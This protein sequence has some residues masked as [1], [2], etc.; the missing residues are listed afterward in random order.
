MQTIGALKRQHAEALTLL[1]ELEETYAK[2]ALNDKPG[3]WRQDP[4]AWKR[5]IGMSFRF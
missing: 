3:G 5:R 2:S 1:H 4:V